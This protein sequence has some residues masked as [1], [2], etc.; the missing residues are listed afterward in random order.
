M[1]LHT[2]RSFDDEDEDEQDQCIVGVESM[3]SMMRIGDT[4]PKRQKIWYENV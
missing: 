3:S 4:S 2:V 1:W